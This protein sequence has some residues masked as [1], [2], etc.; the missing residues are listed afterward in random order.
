M[1]LA[2]D[3]HPFARGGSSAIC[4]VS[5][6]HIFQASLLAAWPDAGDST[7]IIALQYWAVMGHGRLVL[8]MLM[9]TCA[10]VAI[11]G[12]ILRIGWIRILLL[13][14]QQL[15]LGITAFGGLCATIQGAYLDHTAMPW[16][17][18]AADQVGYAALCGIHVVAMVKRARDP[19]G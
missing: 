12:A 6:M 7:A 13:L 19:N 10:L 4:W 9:M 16:P 14:P 15:L 8:V 18:I 3:P 2:I 17:H 5:L 1:K 11:A